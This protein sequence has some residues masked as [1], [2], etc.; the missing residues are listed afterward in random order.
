MAERKLHQ[1]TVD[2]LTFRISSLLLQDPVLQ[3]VVVKG[4][5]AELKKHTSGHV[6]FTLLG[7]ESRISCAL[8]RNYIPYVPQWP[9]NGDE[10]LAEG[11]V[12]LYPPRGAYQLIVRRL[13]P[14]GK[15]AAERA[16]L[17]LEQRLEAEG[18]FDVRLKRPIPAFP[19]KVAVVT[20]RTGAALRDVLAV[21][22]KR[23]P[24]CTLVVVPA[25][26]QGYE[27]PG[28]ICSALSNAG[29][30][31]GAECVLLVRG[32]GSRDDLTPFD[33][34]RVVRAVRNCPLPI[35]T[36]V[37][38]EI[39]ETL[40]DK[41]ADVRAA[42]PSAAAERV[43][44]DS[45]DILASLAQKHR[46]LRSAMDR[47]VRSFE[48]DLASYQDRGRTVAEREIALRVSGADLF[49]SR[50]G[51]AGARAVAA[52]GER[53]AALGASMNSLSPLKVF[54]RGYSLC[55]K[56]GVPV[57][58]AGMLSEGD[59][60]SLRFADGDAAAVVS[61]VSLRRQG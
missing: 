61:G 22:G 40:S 32:G 36:G 55:E 14:L 23:M 53:I 10:V 42:T 15:G 47:D 6:Y 30:V 52:A 50:L 21:A 51:A 59:G 27:A 19:E 49:A 28:E 35:V 44:P 46:L 29:R 20:S 12:S 48:K 11:A 26:V 31:E 58:S 41:A 2:E 4:E 39:D 56:D 13:V 18:L 38:H 9:R 37:G 57:T 43:F 1:L 45:A 60:V 34:E 7:G 3:S 5:L 17:E 33:D 16:R 8:F 24:S 25:Q 54:D